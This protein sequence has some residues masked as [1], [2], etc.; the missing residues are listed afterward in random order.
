MVTVSV[1][2]LTGTVVVIG[3]LVHVPSEHEVIV[4]T[5]VWDSVT[6]PVVPEEKLVL[7]EIECS[8]ELLEDDLNVKILSLIVRV[9]P[10]GPMTSK[11]NSDDAFMLT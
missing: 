9:L 8:D 3:N 11:P 5:I 2:V 7:E 4:L 1:S 6:V 10:L